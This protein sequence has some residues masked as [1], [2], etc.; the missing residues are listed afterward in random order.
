MKK[1]KG[2]NSLLKAFGWGVL[3]VAVTGS[4][5][6]FPGCGRNHKQKIENI[7]RVESKYNARQMEMLETARKNGVVIVFHGALSNDNITK[8]SELAKGKGMAFVEGHNKFAYELA[9]AAEDSVYGSQV[10]LHSAGSRNAYKFVTKF[11]EEGGKEIR[12]V[13]SLDAYTSH[14]FPAQVLRVNNF[15]SSNFYMFRK[16]SS[17]GGAQNSYEKIPN[18]DHGSVPRLA[19]KSIEDCIESTKKNPN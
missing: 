11:I 9:R 3:A 14:E 8:G 6:M 15:D 5:T 4:G 17:R 12:G 19:I 10:V 2:N 1:G 13:Q 16:L 7:E 18:S